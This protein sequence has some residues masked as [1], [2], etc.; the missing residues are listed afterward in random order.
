QVTRFFRRRFQVGRGDG[1][2]PRATP[3][4]ETIERIVPGVTT[5]AEVLDLC[6]PP[7]E[8]HES[9]AGETHRTLIYRDT[10]RGA[11]KKV[12]VDPHATVSQ[13]VEERRE[14]EIVCDGERVS[15]V[16]TRV[17]RARI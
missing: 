16:L 14:V 9:V 13:W 11:Q 8:E 17:R 1:A 3:R 12:R 2:R 4:P 15:D 7:D 10:R 5:R 6:G